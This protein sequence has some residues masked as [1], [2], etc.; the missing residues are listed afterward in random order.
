MPERGSFFLLGPRQ[1]GKST[2]I[3]AKFRSRTWKLDLL[4]SESFFTYSKDPALFRREALEKL[5]NR[6]IDAIFIDE[7]QRVPALLN[8]IHFLMQQH[9]DCRFILTGSSARKLRRG[10]VNLLAGRAVERRLFPF[11]Y[12]EISDDFNLDEAL[13][14]GTLP[15]L[16]GRDREEKRDILE[17]YVHTYLQTEIQSEGIARNL[18]GFSRFLDMAASQFGE[19]LN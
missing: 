18:G 8:E 1:T 13:L 16:L 19:L 7:I 12:E 6:Q 10:G 17:A 14:F 3:D 11:V 4:L 5:N 2:L 15:P 9:P